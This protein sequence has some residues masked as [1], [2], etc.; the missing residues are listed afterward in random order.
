MLTGKVLS[1]DIGN[2]NMHLVQGR[3]RGNTADLEIC[4][5]VP[6]PE[7]AIKDGVIADASALRD[8]LRSLVKSSRTTA[9]RAII[10]IKSTNIINREITV[11]M[12]KPE[13]LQQLVIF[14]M[15]QYVPNI[16]NDYAMGFVISEKT[17][18][19]GGE[20]YKLR[21]SAAP[22]T[23]VSA[24]AELLRSIGL[25]PTIMDTPAN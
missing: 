16:S 19:G 15:E 18:A 8:A 25:K 20:Q 11:P 9:D 23:M 4:Q 7:G 14:E 24:Y 3:T 5:Q 22:R 6:T 1:L 13:E 12:V 2:R 17:N 21:V 10:S